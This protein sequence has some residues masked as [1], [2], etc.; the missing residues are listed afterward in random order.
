MFTLCKLWVPTT[1]CAVDK[2]FRCSEKNSCIIERENVVQKSLDP[3]DYIEPSDDYRDQ[4]YIDAR[5]EDAMI[6]NKEY[7][8][9]LR[10]KK[11]CGE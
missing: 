7:L 3:Q 9:E 1:I 2:K 10:E 8:R 11:Y 5:S 4:D 6:E